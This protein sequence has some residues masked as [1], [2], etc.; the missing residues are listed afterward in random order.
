MESKHDKEYLKA[1]GKHIAK[2]RIEKGISQEALSFEAGLDVMTISRIERGLLNISVLN[3][4]KIAKVLEI[5]P[6]KLLEFDNP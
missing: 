5:H 1:F 6:K 4:V 2:K 3:L